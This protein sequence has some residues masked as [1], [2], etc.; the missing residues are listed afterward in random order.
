MYTQSMPNYHPQR[1]GTPIDP[2]LAE[3]LRAVVRERGSK[4]VVQEMGVSPCALAG[5]CSGS[6]VVD[7]TAARVRAYL[8]HGGALP[9]WAQ[10]EPGAV[11]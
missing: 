10:L 7:T 4:R 2:T 8:E 11:E 3:R 5:A 1:T 9:A 6:H